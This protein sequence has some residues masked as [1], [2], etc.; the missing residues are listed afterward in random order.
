MAN[1]KALSIG[2]E[3]DGRFRVELGGSETGALQSK[4]DSHRETP[5]VRGGDQF[6]G[7]RALFV[8]EAR[9]KRI[10]SV[11]EYAGVGREIAAAAATGPPPNGLRFADHS[12]LLPIS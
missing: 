8:F 9:L 7:I 10:R 1:P 5:G 2:F 12:R 4:R 3:R 6:F 11:R